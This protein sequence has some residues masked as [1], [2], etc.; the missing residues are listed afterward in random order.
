[1]A[2]IGMA[3]PVIAKNTSGVFSDAFVCGKATQGSLTPTTYNVK[4]YGDDALAENATG[5][6]DW[7]ISL[8]LTTL[9]I[10]AMDVLFGHTVDA[11]NKTVTVAST[12]QANAVGVGF[13]ATEMVDGVASYIAYWFPNVKF[14]ESTDSFTTKGETV[15]FAGSTINGTAGV[16]ASNV[17]KYTKT[18]TTIAAAEAWLNEKAGLEISST[19][20][21][22]VSTGGTTAF[23]LSNEGLSV[24]NVTGTIG[25]ATY[26]YDADDWSV[27]GTTLTYAGA[28]ATIA[29]DEIEVTYSHY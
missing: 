20:S 27:S 8:G 17:F 12:D 13:Y 6:T 5:T 14:T 15:T 19:E 21:F 9:P 18:F 29:D 25:G 26:T 4:F 16:D 22:T 1:M 10:G 3:Y 2:F 24:T 28:T 23:T 11:V 7:A